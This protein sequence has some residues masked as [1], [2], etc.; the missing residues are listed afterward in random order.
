M[1]HSILLIGGGGHAKSI[2]DSLKLHDNIEMIG[3]IDTKDKYGQVI[4]GIEII[5]S[6]EDLEYY[7]TKGVKQAFISIG[8]IGSPQ[9]RVKVYETIK[10]IGYNL[11][12]VID[13]SAIISNNITLGEGNYI[14][15]GAIL[16]TGIKVG[17][18]CIIN[19]GCII[20]HGCMIDDF[21]HIAPGSTLCGEVQIGQKTHIGA[22]TVIIQSKR[23]GKESVIG[24][25]SVVIN[26][27]NEHVK[28]YGSPC[29]EVSKIE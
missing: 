10:K 13:S 3:I 6:D 24:A 20:E 18:N 8:S 29:R 23:I 25:G 4:D 26:D 1:K 2:I 19:T 16:N 9:I 15:K 21:V 22:G 11:P 17:N 27:I 12:N 28:A 7:Y 5:G 14:G